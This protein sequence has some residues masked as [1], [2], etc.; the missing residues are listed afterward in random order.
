MTNR[1]DGAP[2]S[3]FVHLEVVGALL[4]LVATGVALVWAN[5]PWR[6]SYGS[7][8][9][10][11][12]VGGLDRQE[13]VDDVLMSLFFFV[14]G[15]EIKRELVTG[16]LRDPRSIALPVAA[17]LGGMVAPALIFTAI[18]AGGPGAHG[19]G[20]P[21][22]TDIAFA[23]GVI[24]LLGSRVPP[25]LKV[26]LLTLAIVDDIGGIVVIAA[27]YSDSV[28]LGWLAVA[29]ALTVGVWVL[30]R[31][32]LMRLPVLVVAGAALWFAVHASGVHATIAGVV[33]GLSMPAGPRRP[34]S[35]P[36]CE[37]SIAAL[38]PWT[39]ALIVP[40]FALANAGVELSGG[41]LTSPSPVL[42]GV[43]AG[44]VVGKPLGIAGA[45]WL[46]VRSGAARLPAGVRW[47]HVVGMGAVAGIGFTVALFIADL[48]FTDDLLTDAK[49]GIL[50]A[51][52]I[53]SLA[54]GTILAVAARRR[55]P[56]A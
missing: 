43:L 16:E 10:G 51:S 54:G 29:G 26:L 19:W 14:V 21:I 55:P 39:S 36:G 38:H 44:L 23:L 32:G 3:R 27:F 28:A 5:S 7:F 1:P 41:A 18:V 25:P 34:M 35:G 37:R 22:A 53:A 15:M 12:S 20:V 13:L 8:W 31:R 42:L 49:V 6:A 46:A 50:A 4:L 33:L 52:L 9:S 24:A 45:A 2:T 48:S 11:G 56:G 47:V 40:L 17:A 30:H